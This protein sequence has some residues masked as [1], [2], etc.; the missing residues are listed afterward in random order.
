MNSKQNVPTLLTAPNKTFTAPTTASRRPSNYNSNNSTNNITSPLPRS[1]SLELSDS[2]SA[3]SAMS[4]AHNT[5]Q[6]QLQTNTNSK[7]SSVGLH[8]NKL[9]TEQHY[10]FFS[11]TQLASIKPICSTTTLTDWS[12]LS[13][14][15]YPAPHSS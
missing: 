7:Y 2:F 9:P 12:F 8:H 13:L 15:K 4:T 3:L 10:Q 6:P 5:T 1:P 14:E 11:T